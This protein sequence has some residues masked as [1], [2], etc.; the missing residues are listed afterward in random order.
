MRKGEIKM[1]GMT[2]KASPKAKL[3]GVVFNQ[4]LRWKLHVK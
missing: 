4:E 2:I 3:L 1:N